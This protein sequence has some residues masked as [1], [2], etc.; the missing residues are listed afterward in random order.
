MEKA[1]QATALPRPPQVNGGNMYWG[2]L[3]TLPSW[4]WGI[5]RK[6][7]FL[8]KSEPCVYARVYYTL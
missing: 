2:N 7:T 8:L 1:S 4:F 6:D 3:G 5:L